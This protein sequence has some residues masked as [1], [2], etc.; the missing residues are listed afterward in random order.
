[1]AGSATAAAWAPASGWRRRHRTARFIRLVHERGGGFTVSP[2]AADGG[3]ARTTGEPPAD[4]EPRHLA[5]ELTAH[6]AAQAARLADLDLADLGDRQLEGLLSGLRTPS[7]L[8]DALRT[9]VMG[10]LTHRRAAQAPPGQQDR[11]RDDTRRRLADQQQLSP[12][13][14][15]RAAD[16]DRATRHRPAIDAAYR[17]GELRDAHVTPLMTALEA[18]PTDRQD[19]VEEELLALARRLDPTA[20]GRSAR[21]IAA[22]EDVGRTARQERR[23]HHRRYLRATDTIDGGFAISGL[24]YGEMAERARVALR[25]FRRPDAPGE[26]RPNDHRGADAFDQ[27]CAAAL[28][29]GEAPAQHGTRPQVLVIVEA[30][31]LTRPLGTARFASGQPVTTRELGSLLQDC[32]VA[33]IAT[34]ASG[35]PIEASTMVRTVP[36]GLW[37]ALVVRDGGCTWQRCDAPAS[38]C[39]VAHGQV[40]FRAGGKLSPDNAALLCRRHHRLFDAGGWCIEVHGATVTYRRAVPTNDRTDGDTGGPPGAC[41]TGLTT[42]GQQRPSGADRALPAPYERSSPSPPPGTPAVGHPPTPSGADPPG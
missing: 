18:T 8:I 22:R 9:R 21:Q 17:R 29:A 30:H 20:F 12:S 27:L 41:N 37:R 25:A 15:R 32:A 28:R 13:E 24:L 36:A 3:H 26:H 10:E 7:A 14:S 19:D 40:A 23:Q 34:D 35:A 4:G 11:V 2:P 5:D 33:R 1:M 6:L 38:W 39:D 42:D 16:V 31:E